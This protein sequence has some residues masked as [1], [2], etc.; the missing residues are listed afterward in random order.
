MRFSNMAKLQRTL[1]R[2]ENRKIE[3]SRF[4]EVKIVF[5]FVF[6]KISKMAQMQH[7]LFISG[8]LDSY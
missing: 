8:K 4:G 2:D 3:K 6:G 7:S 5:D 1:S